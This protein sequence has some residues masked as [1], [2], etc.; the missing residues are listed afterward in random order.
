M[1][2]PSHSLHWVWFTRYREL[3]FM[4]MQALHV[5]TKE[6][7]ER[8]TALFTAYIIVAG[9]LTTSTFQAIYTPFVQPEELHGKSN[10]GP[11]ADVPPQPAVIQDSPRT[12]S[13]THGMGPEEAALPWRNSSLLGNATLHDMQIPR[14]AAGTSNSSNAAQQDPGTCP[15][16]DLY[17]RLACG[18]SFGFSLAVV[19]LSVVSINAAVLVFSDRPIGFI[20]LAAT[21]INFIRVLVHISFFITLMTAL[22]ALYFGAFKFFAEYR[23][24]L[25]YVVSF[26][27]FLIVAAFVAVV[28]PVNLVTTRKGFVISDD[29]LVAVGMAMMEAPFIVSEPE[30]VTD[31]TIDFWQVCITFYRMR[32]PEDVLPNELYSTANL[33]KF[34]YQE[35]KTCK[36]IDA[37]KVRAALLA[38]TNDVMLMV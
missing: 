25:L 31:I 9:L 14:A 22:L 19:L 21:M 20:H 4:G 10:P 29:A 16:C 7:A 36:D 35:F 24:T 26:A 28:G 3:L 2:E 34:L 30:N 17:F 5:F 6:A 1:M 32:C 27:A 37:I 38:N 15:S 11:I 12:P 18:V 33:H 13:Y 8:T 23:N